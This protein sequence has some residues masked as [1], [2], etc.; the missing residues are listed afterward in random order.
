MIKKW[1][2]DQK[3]KKYN[4]VPAAPVDQYNTVPALP[5]DDE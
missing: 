2:N 4:A 1:Y 3:I 5:V